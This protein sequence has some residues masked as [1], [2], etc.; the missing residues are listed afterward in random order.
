MEYIIGCHGLY[1]IFENV[2]DGEGKGGLHFAS[3][4][5]CETILEC[6]SDAM[7]VAQVDMVH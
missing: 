7:L 3:H 6:H 5:M 2:I 1:S 4:E